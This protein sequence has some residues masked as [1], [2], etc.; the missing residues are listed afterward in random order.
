MAPVPAN[1]VTSNLGYFSTVSCSGSYSCVAVGTYEDANEYQWALLD[2]FSDGSWTTTEAP[3]PANAGDNPNAQLVSSSCGGPGS[4]V[5]VG[6]YTDMNGSVDDLIETLS[7]GVWTATEAPLPANGV[8][9]FGDELKSVSCGGPGSCVA[10]GQYLDE[11]SGEGGLIE[12]LSDGVWTATKAPVPDNGS[13]GSTFLTSVS[14]YG[15]GFCVTDG[16]GIFDTLSNGTWTAT[17]APNPTNFLSCDGPGSCVAVV[18]S[19]NPHTNTPPLI[20]TLWNGIWTVTEAPL[21]ANAGFTMGATPAAS[22]LSVSCDGP[23]FC[24]AVG[25]YYSIDRAEGLIETN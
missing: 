11:D 4:C 6:I 19:G 7:D 15:T 12:T 14:C 25:Q 13:V 24:V 22:L 23:S 21:P 10:V 3:L 8:A 2:T 1:A 9:W 18:Q 17:E 20:E 5:A 16:G